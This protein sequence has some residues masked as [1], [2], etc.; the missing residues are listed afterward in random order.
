[1]YGVMGLVNGQRHLENIRTLTE[2]ISQEGIKEVVPVCVS[3][4]FQ[5]GSGLTIRF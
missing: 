2:F 1:M 5:I 3:L 4:S